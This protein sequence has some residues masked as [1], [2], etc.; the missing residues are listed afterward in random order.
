MKKLSRILLTLGLGLFL[1]SG[2]AAQISATDAKSAKPDEVVTL[3]EFNV[4]SSKTNDYLAAESTTGTRVAT[5]IQ[6]LPFNV[7]VVTS[8]FLDDF[9]AVDFGDQLGYVSSFSQ[10]EVQGQYQLRG[11]VAS[12]QLV[13]GFRRLGLVDKIN[14]DRI[15]VIKGPAASIY[16]QVQPGG[17]VNI[18]TKKPKK[19]PEQSLQVQFGSLSYLRATASSTG[20]VGDSRKLF[21]R[22]DVSY[23]ERK[24]AQPFKSNTQTYGSVVLLYRP[25]ADTNFTFKIDSVFR[26]EHPGAQMPFERVVVTDPFRLP[27][28]LGVPRTYTSYAPHL[29]YELFNFNSMGPN[30]YTDR[31][32]TTATVSMERRISSVWSMRAGFNAFTRGYHRL[33]VSQGSGYFPIPQQIQGQFPEFDNEPAKGLAGQ[34]DAVAAFATGDIKHKLLFTVDYNSETDRRDNRRMNAVDGINPLYSHLNNLSVVTPDYFFVTYHQNSAL[35]TDT[36][37][38]SWTSYDALG[39]FVS[40]RTSFFHD[41]LIAMAGLRYDTVS[42]HVRDYFQ[43]QYPDYRVHALTHQFG[44]TYRLLPNVNLYVNDSNSFSPQ[45]QVDLNS[46]PIPNETGKGWEA[47]TKLA[48][49]N[50]KLNLTLAYYVID[51]YNILNSVTSPVKQIYLSG[52]E[53]A[54]GYEMDFNWQATD[55]LQFLGGYGHADAKVLENDALPYL[56]GSTPRRVPKDNIGLA[57]RYEVKQGAL[58]GLYF[59]AGVK[60][61]SRS[62][63][64]LGSGRNIS[65]ASASNPFIN[66]PMNNGTLPYPQ[67]PAGTVFNAAIGTVASSTV[68]PLPYAVRVNDGRDAVFNDPYAV[69]DA[70]I[71]YRFKVKGHK[72]QI[73]VNAKNILNRRYTYGSASEGEPFTIMASYTITL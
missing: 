37:D 13:D 68:L 59:T 4:S 66:N 46:Q 22:A 49:F 39:F 62:T 30:Q 14:V 7:N 20:P 65:S 41:K 38:N 60:Y 70:G 47:G 15:E 69:V 42:N 12:A 67:Y 64:N 3:E 16:G 45:P 72:N 51:R 26:H 18:V 35:Y 34:I 73:Q 21:Y 71:G 10:S 8:E 61:Y 44:V 53:Q 25:N 1:A 55:A 36:Q 40:E 29:P 23:Q 11:F 9:A 19:K 17:L 50:E 32:Q 24:S 63:I 57:S 58:K 48:L 2:V 56:V 33:W 27:T 43:G 28:S 6:D 52:H 54:K 31:K 5:K